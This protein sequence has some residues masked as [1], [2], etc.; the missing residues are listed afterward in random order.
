M[1]PTFSPPQGSPVY[2]LPTA[3]GSTRLTCLSDDSPEIA[4]VKAGD[5]RFF[6][7]NPTKTFRV[8]RSFPWEYDQPGRWVCVV[9]ISPGYRLRLPVRGRSRPTEAAAAEM[10]REHRDM[11]APLAQEVARLRG[12]AA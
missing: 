9:Q 10:A 11:L 12:R 4:S 3:D 1:R 7:A 8:R 5:S 6:E 2:R